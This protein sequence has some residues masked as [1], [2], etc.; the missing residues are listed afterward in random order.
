MKAVSVKWHGLWL[1]TEAAEEA[2]EGV[3]EMNDHQEDLEEA[4]AQKSGEEGHVPN[5]S[6][7]RLQADGVPEGMVV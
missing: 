6:F 3:E 1:L 4:D 7:Q 5:D 2:Q